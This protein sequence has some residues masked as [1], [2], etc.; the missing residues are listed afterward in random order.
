MSA[1]TF[2]AVP[3][4]E[5]ECS[6]SLLLPVA[7]GLGA[8]IAAAHLE[9]AVQAVSSSWALALVLA[10][11]AALVATWTWRLWRG[12]S[13]A[14]ARAGAGLFAALAALWLAS[15]TAGLPFGLAPRAPIGALDALTALDEVLLVGLPLLL[16]RPLAFLTRR[17]PGIGLHRHERLL[18]HAEHGLPGRN[19]GHR[20]AA[21]GGAR[22]HALL[23]P[24]LSVLLQRALLRQAH[25][26]PP[27]GAPSASG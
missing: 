13:V 6:A 9:S 21:S 15:R 26:V 5:Q 24:L 4:R 20:S 10:A 22:V 7:L 2:A 17:G 3:R 11:V 8:F 18:C 14:V 19:L 25:P 16:T 23:S 1:L 12:G 27:P